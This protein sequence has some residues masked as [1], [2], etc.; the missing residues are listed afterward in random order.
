MGT[1]NVVAYGQQGIPCIAGL[2]P[3]ELIVDLFAGGGGA[4][5]GIERALGRSPDHAVN[6]WSR[7]IEC[8]AINHPATVHH[9]TSVW[10]IDPHAI[11]QGQPVGLLHLSPDCTHHSRAKGDV[12]VKKEL[13]SLPWVA[14]RWAAAVAPRVITLEN[15]PEIVQWGPLKKVWRRNRKTGLREQVLVADRKRRGRTWDE[16]I[17][18]LRA[19]GYTVGWQNLCA[20]DFGVATIRRRLFM[21]AR[22]DFD[23]ICWPAPTCSIQDY[24]PGLDCIDL[25]IPVPSMIYRKKPHADNTVQ[26]VVDGA[27]RH[28][29]GAENPV[30]LQLPTE[31]GP[32]PAACW[33]AKHYSGVIGTSLR[34]PL[35]TITAKDHH[36]LCACFL[37]SYYSSGGQAT[38][39]R[40]PLPTVVGKAR[41]ALV[42]C[43]IQ[44]RNRQITDLGMRM[45]APHELAAA[46]GFPSDYVLTGSKADRIKLIGN[47]VVPQVMEALIRAN[48]AP[49]LVAA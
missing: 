28:V 38:D 8:H 1:C 15:V 13:R 48:F 12:P 26:R 24:R 40:R 37:S 17:S 30:I 27:L 25:S 3:G 34:A 7:A 4:S 29:I 5:L 6:H 43:T 31:R 11:A 35:G 45:L 22:R 23:P 39:L 16:F 18:Q 32:Q 19:L 20:A 10:E 21:V 33:I 9:Q 42:A 47:S 44:G 36:A 2:L 14:I 46:Q 49:E 41:H